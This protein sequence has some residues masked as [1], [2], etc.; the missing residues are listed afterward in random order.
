MV[1]KRRRVREA[2]AESRR[3]DESPVSCDHCLKG[4]PGVVG[5]EDVRGVL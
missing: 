1:E 3:E 5:K 2:K 4:A